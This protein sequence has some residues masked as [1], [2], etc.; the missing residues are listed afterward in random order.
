MSLAYLGKHCQQRFRWCFL[1]RMFHKSENGTY[2]SLPD[3]TMAI[4]ASLALART[5]SELSGPGV[6]NV[7]VTHPGGFSS[8][9]HSETKAQCER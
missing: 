5:S 6:L 4:A 9:A 1:G 3:E 2:V 8:G 7:V